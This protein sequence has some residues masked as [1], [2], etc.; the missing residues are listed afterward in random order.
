MYAR[1]CTVSDPRSAL[2][3]G[4]S[5]ARSLR[6][7]SNSCSTVLC[8]FLLLLLLSPSHKSQVS[9][10]NKVR[11][12]RPRG[13]SFNRGGGGG[14]RLCACVCVCVGGL[15]CAHSG[16]MD[17]HQMKPINSPQRACNLRGASASS[18]TA[19]SRRSQSTDRRKAPPPPP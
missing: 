12:M 6:T 11:R 4:Q 7:D 5:S 17:R 2:K 16:C 14:V 8:V 10:W 9:L 13:G 3:W 15:K 19:D 1:R 18:C